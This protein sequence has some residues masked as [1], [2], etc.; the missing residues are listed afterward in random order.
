METIVFIRVPFPDQKEARDFCRRVLQQKIV[1]CAQILPSAETFYTW[2]DVV[3]ESQESIVI[4]KTL[5]ALKER[6]YR[7][8]RKEHSYECPSI[9]SYTLESLHPPYTDWMRRVLEI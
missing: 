5:E 8:I 2:N 7:F 1:A 9:L 3:E 4:L 6:L